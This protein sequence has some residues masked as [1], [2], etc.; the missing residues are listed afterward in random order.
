MCKCEREYVCAVRQCP[1]GRCV[2]DGKSGSEVRRMCPSSS[3]FKV[4]VSVSRVQVWV[5][6][7]GPASRGKGREGKRKW[8][9]VG[10][11]ESTRVEDKTQDQIK[12]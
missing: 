7:S 6:D 8:I 10:L 11:E 12:D 4:L 9:E 5:L 2:M 3:V 1:A